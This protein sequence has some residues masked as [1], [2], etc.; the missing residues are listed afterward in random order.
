MRQGIALFRC[1]APLLMFALLLGSP[2]CGD[3][4]VEPRSTPSGGTA[5]EPAKD[6]GQGAKA[7]KDPG[8]N[9]SAGENPPAAKPGKAPVG[10]EPAG[11]GN[12]SA[13]GATPAQPAQKNDS[14]AKVA[15]PHPDGPRL[16]PDAYPT[17]GFVPDPKK[18]YKTYTKDRT[19]VPTEVDLDAARQ[20]QRDGK[21]LVVVTGPNGIDPMTGDEIYDDPRHTKGYTVW[22]GGVPVRLNA[23]SREEILPMPF[24][25]KQ[26]ILSRDRIAK[27]LSTSTDRMYII[28]VSGV[29]RNGVPYYVDQ[30]GRTVHI[31]DEGVKIQQAGLRADA[32]IVP[33]DRDNPGKWG[34]PY[35]RDRLGDRYPAAEP[36]PA[37]EAEPRGTT[38]AG[39][40]ATGFQDNL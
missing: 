9:K 12:Q 35:W 34:E 38:G 14:Q 29:D 11:T 7:A 26:P 25:P 24:D 21:Q 30:M 36:A 4:E 20:A 13:G 33:V 40:S 1:C 19:F 17:G 5:Q 10:E 8:A 6:K 27:G 15:V 31:I 22:V 23:K 18:I 2:A 16:R 28:P 39:Q 37:K 32:I 3:T